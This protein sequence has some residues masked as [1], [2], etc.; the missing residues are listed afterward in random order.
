MCL[1]IGSAT[2]P[3]N[4][5]LSRFLRR[6]TGNPFVMLSLGGMLYAFAWPWLMTN[7]RAAGWLLAGL[8]A[9]PVAGYL[10]LHLPS[11]Y[12]QSEVEYLAYLL[13][14]WAWLAAL[15]CALSGWWNA[16]LVFST[17]GWLQAWRILGDIARWIPRHE[18]RIPRL[19][20]GLAALAG[21]L[22]LALTL[23]E[24]ALAP[25]SVAILLLAGVAGYLGIRRA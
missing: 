17:L 12:R 20:R 23:G 3:S 8:A 14:F 1:A 10:F 15:G 21:G 25:L 9:Q 4:H 6:V 13:V 5:P 16:T 2:P 22:T 7:H 11:R 24:W 18:D 19:A